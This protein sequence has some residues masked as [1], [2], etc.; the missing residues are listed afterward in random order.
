VV[1][2]EDNPANVPEIRVIENFWAYLK[3]LVYE[4]GW[5][6]KNYIQLRQRIQYCLRKVDMTVV[7]RLAEST[8]HR[9]DAVR[10]HGLVECQ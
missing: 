9:I 6:A 1:S 2:K 8:K 5:K 7:Q 3:S 4:K 10:R